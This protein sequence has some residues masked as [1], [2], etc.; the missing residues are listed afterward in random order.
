MY[1]GIDYAGL[2]TV[3]TTII[4]SLNRRIGNNT[5]GLNDFRDLYD[6][7]RTELYG[8]ADEADA[9]FSAI[10]TVITDLTSTIT[11]NY[12][13]LTN[14]TAPIAGLVTMVNS[15][16]TDIGSLMM[17]V[18]DLSP[19][20]KHIFNAF[21]DGT[22]IDVLNVGDSIKFTTVQYCFPSNEYF[23]TTTGTY[24]CPTAGFYRFY[25][26][27]YRA[28]SNTPATIG[29]GLV[30]NGTPFMR[31]SV[32]YTISFSHMV[33]CAEG[34][35]IQVVNYSNSAQITRSW[36]STFSGEF[37]RPVITGIF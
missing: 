29:V 22:G 27:I 34:D 36:Y 15:H 20:N 37:V 7:E 9:S 13:E 10:D 25:A 16:V 14:A 3:D 21:V 31:A 6:V 12:N 11:S 4:D 1:L 35:T 24:T 18:N 8:R 23:D 19:S 32:Q 2:G 28:S 30:K 33:Q 26:T 17:S 5:D